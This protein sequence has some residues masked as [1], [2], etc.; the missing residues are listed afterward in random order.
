MM[1]NLE[2]V[3]CNICN[4]A[5]CR[6]VKCIHKRRTTIFRDLNDNSVPKCRL[7]E[8]TGLP[9]GMPPS[10]NLID[11]AISLLNAGYCGE[12]HQQLY[13]T[14]EWRI[15]LLKKENSHRKSLESELTTVC[16][17]LQKLVEDILFNFKKSD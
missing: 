12:K 9:C 3:K 2:N 4:E 15:N 6:S 11:G 17:R 16:E 14:G 8:K 13:E 1:E 5:N 10:L 7:V